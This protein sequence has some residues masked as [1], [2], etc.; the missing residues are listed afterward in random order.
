[1][2]EAWARLY[3]DH[4]SQ[5]SPVQYIILV[6]QGDELCLSVFALIN[7]FLHSFRPNKPQSPLSSTNS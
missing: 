1:M 4:T 5:A 7:H 3:P 2:V 6:S